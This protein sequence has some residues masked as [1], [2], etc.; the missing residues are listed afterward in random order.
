MVIVPS[1]IL[2]AI[3]ASSLQVPI[4]VFSILVGTWFIDI[5]MRA[6]LTIVEIFLERKNE[7][8]EEPVNSLFFVDLK[9]NANRKSINIKDNFRQPDNSI[10]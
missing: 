4:T 8:S 3:L 10:G 6:L 2:T 1:V 7:I 9:L 5:E